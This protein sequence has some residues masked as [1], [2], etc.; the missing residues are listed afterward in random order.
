MK[1][2]T[3]W[4]FIAKLIYDN[5]GTEKKNINKSNTIFYS[6]KSLYE[7]CE[8]VSEKRS[9][10]ETDY[11]FDLIYLPLF[12]DRINGK[13]INTN[14]RRLS[15]S[16]IL[17]QSTDD[18]PRTR[19]SIWG[20]LFFVEGALSFNDGNKSKLINLI[21]GCCDQL[22][23]AR[24]HF[25]YPWSSQVVPDGA[26]V[27]YTEKITWNCVKCAKEIRDCRL[28]GFGGRGDSFLLYMRRH[29]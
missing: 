7:Y 9:T 13:N 29:S 24:T 16:S 8:R 18:W 26:S 19:K 15:G 20:E 5:D 1:I 10:G 12:A 27:L 14:N 4:N 22:P 17:L 6:I 21:V 11:F 28:V 23:K 25:L 3:S 2:D